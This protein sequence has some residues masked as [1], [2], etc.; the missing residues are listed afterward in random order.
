LASGVDD[1]CLTSKLEKLLN[2][3]RFAAPFTD[4]QGRRKLHVAT[5]SREFEAALNFQISAQGRDD[6]F[7]FAGQRA[8]PYVLPF[9]S[10]DAKK[11]RIER[12]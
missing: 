12:A 11:Y 6:G 2:K 5:F 4:F 1:A 8:T 9:W 10:K 7:D 3:E